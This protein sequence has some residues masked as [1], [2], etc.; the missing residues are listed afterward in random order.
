MDLVKD[1]ALPLTEASKE[2]GKK[3][4]VGPYRPSPILAQRGRWEPALLLSQ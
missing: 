1:P 4:R 2:P 3:C